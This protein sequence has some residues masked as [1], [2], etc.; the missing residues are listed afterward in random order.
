MLTIS[1][2]NGSWQLEDYMTIN[3]LGIWQSKEV[4]AAQ[5]ALTYIKHGKE[6]NEAHN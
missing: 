2:R 3:T 6:A 1:P 5:H 4:A